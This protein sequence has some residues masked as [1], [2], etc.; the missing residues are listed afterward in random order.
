MKFVDLK[1]THSHVDVLSLL[2]QSRVDETFQVFEKFDFGIQ[3]QRRL[4]NEAS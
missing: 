1:I 3:Y 2:D 4:L